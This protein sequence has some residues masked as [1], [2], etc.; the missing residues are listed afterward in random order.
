MDKKSKFFFEYILIVFLAILLASDYVLFIVPN[1][2]A[3]AGVG[4]IA[5]MIE[6]KTGFSIGF[7]TLIVNVPLSVF[8][9]FRIDRDFAV[10]TFVYAVVYSVAYFLL[11]LYV[12]N[13]VKYDAEGIDTIF[14][15]LI[16]GMISGLVY[17]LSFRR[18]SSTGGFDI[19]SKY[20]SKKHPTLNFF[21]ISFFIN[22][23]IAVASLFVYGTGTEGF[24][25]DYKPVC[26][27]LLYIF[28]S[29]FIGNQMLKGSNT[30]YKFTVITTKAEEIEKEV[31]KTL[32][33]SA[34]RIEGKGVYSENDKKVLICVVNKHQIVDF[35]RIL[36]RYGET[37]TFVETVNETVGNFKK[38]K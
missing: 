5:T 38:I 20:V 6:Y 33:H 23:T 27:C 37:F 19:V 22:A 21:W 11:S 34:T 18:N 26:L 14:P 13:S 1:K 4:G 12:P 16:A 8:A 31:I 24:K 17:G 3:P 7:L 10:K 28:L 30:A 29:N 36:Y 32:H 15:C 9:F 25:L 2:F 35:K